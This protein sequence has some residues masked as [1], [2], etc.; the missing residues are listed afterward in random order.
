MS[1]PVLAPQAL[2]LHGVLRAAEHGLLQ[3]GQQLLFE[4]RVGHM[5]QQGATLVLR[6][7]KSDTVST[8]VT[9]QALWVNQNDLQ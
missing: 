9:V 3:R 7:G 6:G 5:A 4:L 1:G 8:E 2:T